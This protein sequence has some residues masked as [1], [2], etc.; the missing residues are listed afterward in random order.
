MKIVSRANNFEQVNFEISFVISLLFI[1][2]KIGLLH[3]KEHSKYILYFVISFNL[4][5]FWRIFKTKWGFY[6]TVPINMIMTV[7]LY[8]YRLTIRPGLAGTVPVF[9]LLEMTR[10][11]KVRDHFIVN[12]HCKSTSLFAHTLP[13]PYN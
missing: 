13:H 8:I 3:R 6:W 12:S 10:W 2:L 7:C 4:T 11:F 1:F 9:G 5:I